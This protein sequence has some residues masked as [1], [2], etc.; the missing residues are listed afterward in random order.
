[1]VLLR[2][3]AVLHASISHAILWTM[4]FGAWTLVADYQFGPVWTMVHGVARR[5]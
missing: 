4:G 2:C 5:L 3:G 1:M